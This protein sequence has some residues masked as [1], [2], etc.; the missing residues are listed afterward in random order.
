[1]IKLDTRN[2]HDPEVIKAFN[3]V[4]AKMSDEAILRF[5]LQDWADDLDIEC[6][7]RQMNPDLLNSEK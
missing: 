5:I 3:E 7:T 2:G 6:F 4:S 1:M